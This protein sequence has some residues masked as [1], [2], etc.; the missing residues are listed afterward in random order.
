M[1]RHMRHMNLIVTVKKVPRKQVCREIVVTRLNVMWGTD[2]KKIYV[3][4]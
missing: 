2:F 1:R 3:D 4:S